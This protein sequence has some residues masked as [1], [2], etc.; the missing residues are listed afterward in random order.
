MIPGSLEAIAKLNQVGYTV[1]V[2]TNQSCVGQGIISMD[3]LNK[4]HQKLQDDLSKINGKIDKFFICPHKEADNCLCRKPKS[5]LLLQVADY[6]KVDL[7]NVYMV[8]DRIKDVLAAKGVS[9]KPILVKSG[10][11]TLKEENEGHDI[12]QDVPTYSDLKTF[13]DFLILNG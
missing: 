10:E 8:G 1:V 9:S 13:V 5:G 4:I 6:Y 7:K 3:T 11:M 12:L 2:C